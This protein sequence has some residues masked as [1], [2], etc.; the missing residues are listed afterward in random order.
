MSSRAPILRQP[1]SLNVSPGVIRPALSAASEVIGL[2]IEP[3]G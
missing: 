2:K 1:W 3:V